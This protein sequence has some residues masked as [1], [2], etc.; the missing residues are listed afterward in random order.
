MIR[1][2]FQFFFKALFVI[3]KIDDLQLFVFE[4]KISHW[5]FVRAKNGVF[6]IRSNAEREIVG[7]SYH[8]AQKSVALKKNLRV[9]KLKD[10]FYKVIIFEK[11]I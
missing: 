4:A 8:L 10:I 3:V 5:N 9:D 7:K 11:Q 1:F 6:K 2:L